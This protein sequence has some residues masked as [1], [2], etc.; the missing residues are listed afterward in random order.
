MIGTIIFFGALFVAIG[1]M[2]ILSSRMV[3][4]P[5]QKERELEEIRRQQK[6]FWT[7]QY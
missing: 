2:T 5:Y 7:S 4:S 1:V 6:T 3:A